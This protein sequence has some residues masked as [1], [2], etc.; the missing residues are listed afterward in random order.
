MDQIT[1]YK[2]VKYNPLNEIK[3]NETSLN[4]LALSMTSNF[5][6]NLSTD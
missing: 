6:N 2:T 5:R 4:L 1:K 3:S